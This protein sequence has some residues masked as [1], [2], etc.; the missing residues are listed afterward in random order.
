[1]KKVYISTIECYPI[2][3]IKDRFIILDILNEEGVLPITAMRLK[4]KKIYGFYEGELV[5]EK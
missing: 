4:D 5:E 3:Y 2:F 1:M